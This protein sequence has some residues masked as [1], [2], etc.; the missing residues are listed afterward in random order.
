VFLIFGLRTAAEL[1]GLVTTGCPACGQHNTLQLARETTKFSVFFVPLVP[2]KTRHVLYCPN[3]GC[4]G[5]VEIS[6]GEARELLAR[7]VASPM[8]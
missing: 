8:G 4:V 5:R 1:L 3:P 6:A 2:I 7:G